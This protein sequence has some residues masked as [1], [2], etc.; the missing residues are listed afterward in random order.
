MPIALTTDLCSCRILPMSHYAGGG[1]SGRLGHEVADALA[2][3][4]DAVE[5]IAGK[6][7]ARRPTNPSQS[8]PS[9]AQCPLDCLQHPCAS[10]D[11][12][13]ERVPCLTSAAAAAASCVLSL[14]AV[15]VC[16]APSW[17]NT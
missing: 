16:R 13:F 7:M 8:N 11:S 2:S 14:C 12:S 17:V 5:K 1:G 4:P 10:F 6:E 9:T 3:M 15:A